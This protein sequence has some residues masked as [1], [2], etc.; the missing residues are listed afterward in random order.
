MTAPCRQV[1]DY[2]GDYVVK[3]V[4]CTTP[5]EQRYSH[6]VT[7]NPHPAVPFDLQIRF[8]Q[9]SDPVPAEF[10][11]NTQFH[12]MKKKSLWLSDGSAGFGEGIDSSFTAGWCW[13]RH[14]TVSHRRLPHSG[15]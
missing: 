14:M 2:S 5:M 15:R 7:C 4:P 12:L 6:P 13:Q 3:L 9:V 11:L 10:S 1:R 8:Q